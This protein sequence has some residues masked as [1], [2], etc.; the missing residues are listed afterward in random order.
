MLIDEKIHFTLLTTKPK[1]DLR[2][3]S[4]IATISYYPWHFYFGDIFFTILLTLHLTRHH[5]LR[6]PYRLKNVFG[7]FG[8]W[9]YFVKQELF[10][11]F[12]RQVI[13]IFSLYSI[14]F[15]FCFLFN[16]VLISSD[17]S[18]FVKKIYKKIST[19]SASWL[20]SYPVCHC[21]FDKRFLCSPDMSWLFS[22]WWLRIFRY[23]VYCSTVIDIFFFISSFF[24]SVCVVHL[25]YSIFFFKMFINFTDLLILLE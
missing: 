21:H 1:P 25:F 2:S 19:I 16:D 14:M 11:Y 17:L 9:F 3:T 8:F 23:L 20:S 18:I 7:I 12:I 5:K 22:S 13:W 10:C 15:F 4:M 24:K 6:A